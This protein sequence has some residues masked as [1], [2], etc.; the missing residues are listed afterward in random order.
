MSKTER[1][2]AGN[3]AG[4]SLLEVMI[5]LSVLS[6]VLVLIWQA[7][8]FGTEMKSRV[9]RFGAAQ[10]SSAA[11]IVLRPIIKSALPNGVLGEDIDSRLRLRADE[12]EFVTSGIHA[13]HWVGYSHIKLT[14][15]RSEV[16]PETWS[17]VLYWQNTAP[18]Q[19][20]LTNWDQGRILIDC[21]DELALHA[22]GRDESGDQVIT[23]AWNSE[24]LPNQIEIRARR[25]N[26]PMRIVFP[27]LFAP[28]SLWG[29]N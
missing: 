12:L 7:I 11:L 20:E 2:A 18:S 25:Q 6:M 19:T 24:S 13:D 5:A 21:L 28:G 26:L 23:D 3:Q 15:Q 10:D 22:T 16:C 17:L 29:N 8:A 1:N 27:L 4:F 14:R 9:D